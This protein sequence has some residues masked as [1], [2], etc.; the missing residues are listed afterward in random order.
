MESKY[1]TLHKLFILLFIT[2]LLTPG[3]YRNQWQAAGKQ[4][5]YDWRKLQ[6]AMVIARIVESRSSGI[7]SH[8]GLLGF[9]CTFQSDCNWITFDTNQEYN[10][11][12]ENGKFQSYFPYTSHPGLQGLF[13][14]FFEQTINFP[15]S[16][17]LRI[18]HGLV[19]LFS[20][21]VL[22]LF[23]IWVIEELGIIAG[24]SLLVFITFSEWM[25]LFSGNI[26]W[27]IWAFYLPFIASNYYLMT[28]A[29]KRKY[30]Q[31]ILSIILAGTIFLKCLFTGF[32]YI[33]TA[34]VMPLLPFIF[35][36][37]RDTWK[38]K[39]Y[40]IKMLHSSISLAAGTAAGLLVLIWQITQTQT[41]FSEATIS[42]FQALSKRS[43][44]NPTQYS[45]EAAS[46]KANLLP[47]LIQY[48][49]GR[50]ILFRHTL[51]D[52]NIGVNIE[53]S[54]LAL[55]F[56]FIIASFILTIIL[57]KNLF[58]ETRTHGFAILFTTWISALAPLS[59]F[60]LFKAHSY[61]HTQMNFIIWQMPFT[62]YGFALCGYTIAITG[63]MFKKKTD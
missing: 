17:N 21:L 24:L 33:T 1:K 44:G 48:V 26:F 11:Y 41:S 27:N 12:K 30:S 19:S 39:E 23:I 54:Y 8:G 53:I 6:E 35:Y 45:Y 5:F 2:L 4:W 56:T 34:L 46:L 49:K 14:S 22:G 32:E 50:A 61:I 10:L 7:L 28:A 60:V 42:I 13:F 51:P 52:K 16:L 55:F 3:F 18:F 63:K 47:V 58:P 40:L 59:W 57:N 29:T 38:W 25:T 9:G 20:A 36:A 31:Y 43:F 37:I 15:P 62:L